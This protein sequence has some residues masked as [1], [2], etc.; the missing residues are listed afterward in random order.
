MTEKQHKWYLREWSRAYA[1]HWCGTRGGEA[2]A[3][4]G[5][6]PSTVRDQVVAAAQRVAMQRGGGLSADALRHG[7]H[8]V[9]LGKDVSSWKL[10]NK[11]VDLV[12]SQ[13]RLL[14]NDADLSAQ[15][16]LTGPAAEPGAS[17]RTRTLYSL[18]HIDLPPA[19]LAEMCRD[20]FGT[21]NWKS[22]PDDK[23]KQFLM[24]AKC[25]AMARVVAAPKKAV[26]TGSL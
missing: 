23:L 5:R 8:I 10:T 26:L 13:F 1:V 6:K 15:M 17:D 3:R 21:S 16:K 18:D 4:P 25:R 22:L 7:C 9:A 12:V 19:Y 24:T 14:R 2:L 11:Q 20:K